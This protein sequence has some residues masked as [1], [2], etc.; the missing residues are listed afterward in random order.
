MASAHASGR[1]GWTRK[2]TVAIGGGSAG[3]SAGGGRW[4][5]A[6]DTAAEIRAAALPVSDLGTPLRACSR[7]S[8]LP[9]AP[10]SGEDIAPM[11]PVPA[12]WSADTTPSS[13]PS[14]T[15]GSRTTPL[16]LETAARPASNWGL[17]R[18]TRSASGAETGPVRTGITL[19]REMKERSVTTS[20]QGSKP[21]SATRR[22]AMVSVRTLVRSKTVTRA[23]ARSVGWS[24][25]WPTS[26]V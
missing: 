22:S 23:S 7:N 19:L 14:Q 15:V 21:G 5:S 8:T 9:A 18:R 3:A 12:S 20:G 10:V 17:T 26:T 16:P 11:M 13:A 1:S 2:V 25:P 4:P 6:S 24:W